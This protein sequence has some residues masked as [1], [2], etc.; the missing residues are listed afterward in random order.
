M[1]K[2]K[3]LFLSIFFAF[4]LLPLSLAFAQEEYVVDEDV[5]LYD[6]STQDS[7]IDPKIYESQIDDAFDELSEA[8]DL[9]TTTDEDA[10]KDGFAVMIASMGILVLFPILIGLVTYIFTSLALSKIGKELGYKNSWFA[11]VPFLNT[12]MLMQLGEK[13]AWWI[14]VPFVGQIM[15]IVAIM[16]ITERRG[17]DKLLGLIV[18]T[19]IGAYVLLYLLAWSPKTGTTAPTNPVGSTN[20]IPVQPSLEDQTQQ[21]VETAPTQPQQPTTPTM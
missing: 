2:F 1:V 18:L 9:I 4:L 15:M 14:L 16:R 7:E 6:T 21:P 20:N 12:I 5:M 8:N 17:Y 11:W 19:G 10:T 3:P 13:S